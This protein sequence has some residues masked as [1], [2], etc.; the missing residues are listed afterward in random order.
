MI[1]G[2]LFD[3]DFETSLSYVNASFKFD[4]DVIQINNKGAKTKKPVNTNFL[5]AFDFF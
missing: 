3:F 4:V 1:T 5:Q 2:M